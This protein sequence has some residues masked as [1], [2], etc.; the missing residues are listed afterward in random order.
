ML[1]IVSL[2]IV[3]VMFFEMFFD[4]LVV[5]INGEKVGNVWVVFNIDF[6]S[7]GGKYKFELENGV[8]NYMVNVEV[9]DVDVMI[10]LN[11]DMLNKIIL[12]EEILKQV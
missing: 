12:K 11:C 8:L 4:F 7:D 2:D 9:K 6:G 3:W 10:I 5:Y 1:N